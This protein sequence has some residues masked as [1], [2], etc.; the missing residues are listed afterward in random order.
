MV[1]LNRGA[2]VG[3]RETVTRSRNLLVHDR[4]TVTVRLQRTG[5]NPRK[6]GLSPPY[7]CPLR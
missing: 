5:V 2:V 3:H 7:D 1:A 4:A 6:A